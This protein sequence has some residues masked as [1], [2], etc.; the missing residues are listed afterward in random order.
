MARQLDIKI[1]PEEEQE[2]IAETPTENPEPEVKEPVIEIEPDE[3]WRKVQAKEYSVINHLNKTPAQISILSV[4]QNSEAHKNALMKV[5]REAYVSNNITGREMANMVG[6]ILEVI[7]S[8][9]TKMS[10]RLRG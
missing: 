6:Q 5:L 2:I 3:L 9:S 10:Y 4:L 1:T 8:S 7:R